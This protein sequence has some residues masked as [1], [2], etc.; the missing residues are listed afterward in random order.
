M[1]EVTDEAILGEMQSNGAGTRDVLREFG[2]LAG[3]EAAGVKPAGVLVFFAERSSSTSGDPVDGELDVRVHA[4]ML[5][6]DPAE[7]PA[8][9]SANIA[10][11]P[12]LLKSRALGLEEAFTGTVNYTVTQGKEMGAESLLRG[13]VVAEGGKVKE[14]WIGGGVVKVGEGWIR[15]PDAE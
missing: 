3:A 13:R 6:T 2:E 8:T 11:G 10:L 15:V 9:G 5:F 14:C 12:V 7:D 1:V 4:R